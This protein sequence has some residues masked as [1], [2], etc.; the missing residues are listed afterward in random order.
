MSTN[1]RRFIHSY[2]ARLQRWH[3]LTGI[4]KAT[5]STGCLNGRDSGSC[6]YNFS[7]VGI[8][9]CRN[10]SGLNTETQTQHLIT[11]YKY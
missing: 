10:S 6:L 2:N 4:C 9:A 5:G 7:K 8:K 3:E 1:V 11:I